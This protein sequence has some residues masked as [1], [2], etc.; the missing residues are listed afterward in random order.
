MTT[1]TPAIT[2]PDGSRCYTNHANNDFVDNDY[3]IKVV[4]TGQVLDDGGSNVRIGVRVGLKKSS[5]YTFTSII[6]SLL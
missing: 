1:Q 6:P 4:H 3:I 2:D 5:G